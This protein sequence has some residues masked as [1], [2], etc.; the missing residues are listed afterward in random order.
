MKKHTGRWKQ[1]E[2]A[3]MRKL[4]KE[5]DKKF[6]GERGDAFWNHIAKLMGRTAAA[7]RSKDVHMHQA[8]NGV[9]EKRRKIRN[10]ASNGVLLKD[11]ISGLVGSMREFEKKLLVLSEKL[12]EHQSA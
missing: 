8:V 11:A 3:K 7:C 10:G 5:V 6:D 9:I 2:Y 4:M 1:T 12:G